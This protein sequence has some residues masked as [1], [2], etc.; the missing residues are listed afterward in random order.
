MRRKTERGEEFRSYIEECKKMVRK[1]E[2]QKKE[3]YIKG[4]KKEIEK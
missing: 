4:K 2:L 1:E 3:N